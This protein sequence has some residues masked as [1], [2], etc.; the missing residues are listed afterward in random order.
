[1]W[2]VV[3]FHL[4]GSE[5]VKLGRFPTLH[6]LLLCFDMPC[7]DGCGICNLRLASFY[8]EDEKGLSVGVLMCGICYDFVGVLI[9]TC[10]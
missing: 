6:V 5:V 1:M 7:V 2:C 3:C 10:H 9:R 8:L 4:G